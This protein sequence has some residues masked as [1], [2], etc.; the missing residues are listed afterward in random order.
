VDLG[1]GQAGVIV[2]ADEDHL[3]AGTPR[4]LASVAVDRVADPLDPPEALGI[5]VEQAA[6][7][8]VFISLGRVLCLLDPPEPPEALRPQM[9]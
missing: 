5:D 2:D 1:V 4:P 9:P 6:G 8:L 7:A 3:P